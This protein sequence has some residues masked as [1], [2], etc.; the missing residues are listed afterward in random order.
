MLTCIKNYTS[1]KLSRSAPASHWLAA[2]AAAPENE[3]NWNSC[4]ITCTIPGS[5]VLHSIILYQ[6]GHSGTEPPQI[7]STARFLS[8]C[9]FLYL[10]MLS[11]QFKP[12]NFP[13]IFQHDCQHVYMHAV[14]TAENQIMSGDANQPRRKVRFKADGGF[15]VFV[16]CF[17][18]FFS[19]RSGGDYCALRCSSYNHFPEPTAACVQGY[20]GM[21]EVD[22]GDPVCPLPV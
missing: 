6:N 4:Y 21:L 19:G 2:P 20:G 17:M 9:A 11:V 14:H 15:S 5:A 3:W 7:V 18:F 1:P 12:L 10:C 22:L 8:V 13:D 16:F